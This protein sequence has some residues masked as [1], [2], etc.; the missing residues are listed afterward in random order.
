MWQSFK[1]LGL[2]KKAFKLAT[3]IYEISKSFPKE[4]FYA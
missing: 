1:D 4:E 3:E 2:Y